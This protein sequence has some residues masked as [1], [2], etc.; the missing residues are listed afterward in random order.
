MTKIKKNWTFSCF[1]WTGYRRGY[2][3]IWHYLSRFL[4][5]SPVEIL[6]FLDFGVFIKNVYNWITFY[7]MLIW[8]ILCFVLCTIH[9]FEIMHWQEWLYD[10]INTIMYFPTFNSLFYMWVSTNGIVTQTCLV[11]CLFRISSLLYNLWT[12]RS[13]IRFASSYLCLLTPV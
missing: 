9:Y 2:S 7:T 11:S 3:T 8:L 5:F 13:V 1:I 6:I 10:K 12:L 4:F